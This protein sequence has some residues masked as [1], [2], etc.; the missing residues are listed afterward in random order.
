MAFL[1]VVF[2]VDGMLGDAGKQINK[3]LFNPIILR[4]MF[5]NVSL[6]SLQLIFLQCQR[7]MQLQL[8][9]QVQVL[10][11]ILHYYISKSKQLKDKANVY[12]ILI[13]FLS[14]RRGFSLYFLA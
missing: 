2:H 7:Q 11:V 5:L 8:K 12:F 1:L 10:K 9:R 6:L 13:F 3:A 4:E 14:K